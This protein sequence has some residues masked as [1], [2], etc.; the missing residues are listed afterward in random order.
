[1]KKLPHS[2]SV[3]DIAI[4]MVTLRAVYKLVS[5]KFSYLSMLFILEL[6]CT[7]CPGM[8]SP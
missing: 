5:S 8:Y 7:A 2:I 4:K 6:A 1:M 3:S